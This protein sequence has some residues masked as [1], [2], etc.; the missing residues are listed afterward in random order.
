MHENTLIL[1][2]VGAL[3]LGM[4][5]LGRIAARFGFSPIPFYL[6]IGLVFG[7]GGIIPLDA[8]EEFFSIGSEIGVILL[9]ALLGLE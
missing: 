3:L 9:L 5:L 2:E 1:I 8:S 6:A 4:S 7:N